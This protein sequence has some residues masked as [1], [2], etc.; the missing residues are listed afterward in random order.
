MTRFAIEHS[1]EKMSFQRYGVT[2][3]S[4]IM[5]QDGSVSVVLPKV[6]WYL[7]RVRHILIHIESNNTVKKSRDAI[8]EKIHHLMSFVVFIKAY[9]EERERF[10]EIHPNGNIEK[11]THIIV[12]LISHGNL[13][14]AHSLLSHQ[15]CRFHSE[16]SD[17]LNQIEWIALIPQG[18]NE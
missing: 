2:V 8:N 3:L 9:S 5:T 15:L 10:M 17:I 16:L 1:W 6:E 4:Q 18:V 13:S 7:D 11:I 12:Q 14:Y